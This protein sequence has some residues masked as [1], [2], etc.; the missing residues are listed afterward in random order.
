MFRQRLAST[1]ADECKHL[2]LWAK[3]R[4]WLKSISLERGFELQD[5]SGAGAKAVSV[6]GA[7]T[8]DIVFP[9]KRWSTRLRTSHPGTAGS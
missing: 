9:G 4:K 1:A 7:A 3:A 6:R 8:A 2:Q 5:C